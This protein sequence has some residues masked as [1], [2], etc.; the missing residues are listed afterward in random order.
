[1]WGGG[2]GRRGNPGD[3]DEYRFSGLGANY[4]VARSPGLS[5][6]L[7][8]GRRLWLG[9]ILE[10]M[11]TK[12]PDRPADRDIESQHQTAEKHR[13]QN[14]D[15]AGGANQAT[16]RLTLGPADRSTG[17]AGRYMEETQGCDQQ[18]GDAQAASPGHRLDPRHQEFGGG[19]DRGQDDEHHAPA[20]QTHE[21]TAEHVHGGAARLERDREHEQP[22]QQQEADPGKL[23]LLRL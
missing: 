4:L 3:R 23:A 13:A 2:V 11:L 22:G 6:S 19:D 9:S 10:V 20:E 18:E 12:S 8:L 15:A 14:Q 5:G 7:L 17:A 21:A 1:M 16:Q